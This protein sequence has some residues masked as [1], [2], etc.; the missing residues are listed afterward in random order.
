MK[1]PKMWAITGAA[2]ALVAL[3]CSDASD[4]GDPS[5]RGTELPAGKV[6]KSEPS[7]TGYEICV[8]A[9]YDDA[10]YRKGEV[11]C[12]GNRSQEESKLCSVG[13]F[14]PECKN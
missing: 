12:K 2:V 14:Y 10:G 13:E 11:A 9:S 8:L 6:V 7:N 1:R 3:Q 5:N 4:P